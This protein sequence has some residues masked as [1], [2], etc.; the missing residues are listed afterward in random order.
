MALVPDHVLEAALAKLCWNG[1]RRHDEYALMTSSQAGAVLN[2]IDRLKEEVELLKTQLR[3]DAAYR[4][5]ERFHAFD[6]IKDDRC[7]SCGGPVIVEETGNA[8]MLRT[9]WKA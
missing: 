4:M 9:K 5:F 6:A 7:P 8:V 2:E 3:E 1:D